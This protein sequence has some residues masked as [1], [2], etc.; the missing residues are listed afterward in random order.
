MKSRMTKE[1]REVLE[2]AQ[3]WGVDLSLLRARRAMTPAARLQR[4]DRALRF[5]QEVRRAGAAMRRQ[6]K[7]LK[8]AVR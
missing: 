5:V 4:H 2:E 6:K 7:G 3:R 1:Q 8:D